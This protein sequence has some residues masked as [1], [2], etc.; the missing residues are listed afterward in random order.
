MPPS[1]ELRKELNKIAL[2]RG[3]SQAQVALNWCRAQDVIPIAGLRN[4]NQAKD[5]VQSLK[6]SL[7]K[8]EKESLDTLSKN[9]KTRMPNNPFQS[10]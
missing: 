7:S 2:D 3:A 5:V 8:K 4:P 10:N 9:C 1:L 6:W